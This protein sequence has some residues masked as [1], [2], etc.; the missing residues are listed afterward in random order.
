MCPRVATVSAMPRATSASPTCTATRWSSSPRTTCGPRRCPAAGPTGS[1]PTTCRWPRPGS[2][3]T[4]PAWRGRRRARVRGEVFVTDVDGGAARRLTWWGGAP[5]AVGWTPAGDVLALSA[6]GQALGRPTWACD[7]PADGGAPRRREHGPLSDLALRPT[8]RRCCLATTRSRRWRGGS[9]TAAGRPASCGGTPRARA[10]SSGSSPR[11]TA[12]SSRRCWSGDRLAFLSDH[13][14][15]GNLYSRRPVG[16]RPAPPHRPRRT[17]RARV[18]RPAREH[19][20]RPGG[21]TSRPASCGSSTPSTSEP[22]LLD[23][24]LGGPRTA[25]EPYRITTSEWL[26]VPCPTGP[27]GR[28]SSASAAPCTGSPT[29][30][31]R[32][33]RCSPTP[34][35]GPGSPSRWATTARCGSTTP[36]ARRP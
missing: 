3:R 9:A 15:W 31:G 20:R 36:T 17:R 10:S 5:R 25:R 13:E 34:A 23:V 18:L 21:A 12:S 14:G 2:R 30:T 22:R 33:A 7:V 19:R 24:R 35:C 4:A 6:A 1:P 26:S 8:A 28:A 32:P 11:S 27:A 16:R 29:A